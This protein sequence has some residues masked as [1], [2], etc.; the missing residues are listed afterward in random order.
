MEELDELRGLN[1]WAVLQDLMKKEMTRMKDRC[2]RALSYH[3]TTACQT[4]KADG[5]AGSLKACGL[6]DVMPADGGRSWYVELRIPHS[7]ERGDF[8]EMHYV[9]QPI[10]AA[11][12]TKS[13]RA[14]LDI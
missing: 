10:A 8:L 3:T 1:E 14:F 6:D 2:R 9:S 13:R 4:Q 5:P 12:E 11:Q 7:F